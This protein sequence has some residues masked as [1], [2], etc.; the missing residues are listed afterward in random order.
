M[1]LND[2]TIRALSCE[3]SARPSGAPG[4]AELLPYVRTIEAE[5][6]SVNLSFDVSG[7]SIVE[8]FVTAEQLCC[9]GLNWS[10]EEDEHVVRL[11]IAGTQGQVV[12]I[13][14]MFAQE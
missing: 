8:S 14:R 7:K 3:I 9:S 13:E 12:V 4:I 1:E 5:P 10:L 11:R 2:E 6:G